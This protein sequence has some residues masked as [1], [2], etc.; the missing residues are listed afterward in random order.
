MVK[1]ILQQPVVKNLLIGSAL[2]N[3]Q[4]FKVIWREKTVKQTESNLKEVDSESD[5]NEQHMSFTTLFKNWGKITK[6][7][8][9][10]GNEIEQQIQIFP[11]G[12]I[13]G[14]TLTR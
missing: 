13:K 11:N 14:L 3:G 6:A 9:G 2:A 8:R 4:Y 5:V 12:Y 1:V 7:G 10:N